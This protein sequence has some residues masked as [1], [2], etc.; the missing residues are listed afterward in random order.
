[1]QIRRE[2][3]SLGRVCFPIRVGIHRGPCIAVNV[4]ES[5]D[6]FG[7]T[8]NLAARLQGQSRG[9]DIVLSSAMVED[10][11]VGGEIAGRNGAWAPT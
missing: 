2:L 11:E 5:I 1:M 8:V 3:D 10:S 7:N 4:G 9:G 6:Y